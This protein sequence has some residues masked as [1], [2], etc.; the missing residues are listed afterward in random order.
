[1]ILKRRNVEVVATDK[2]EIYRLK[3]EGFEPLFLEPADEEEAPEAK[4]LA[5][6]TVK[7]LR[8][9]AEARGLKVSKALRKQDLIDLLEETND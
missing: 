9:E 8:A 7:E 2:E 4:Q 6:M 5:E 3:V 1:M